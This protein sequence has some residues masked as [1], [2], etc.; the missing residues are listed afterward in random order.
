M[1]LLRGRLHRLAKQLPGLIEY[2]PDENLEDAWIVLEPLYYD[3][4]M[5]TAIQE[6]M[7]TFR[8]GDNLTREEA[9]R[10]LYGFPTIT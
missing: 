6:S 2:L 9:L 3:L 1:K 7:I 5:L 4:Y 8:P 10:F